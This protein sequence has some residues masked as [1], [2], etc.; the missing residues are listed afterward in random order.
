MNEDLDRHARATAEARRELV[1]VT[2]KVV[3][4]RAV[5]VG[6]LQDVVRAATQLDDGQAAQLLEA[7]EQLV[8]TALGAQ[9]DAESAVGA[10]D[11]ISRS[12]GLDQLTGLPN[13]ALL[14][15]RLMNAI[16]NAKR[17]DHRVALMFLDLNNF[18]QI[19]DRFGHA[20]GDR[21]LQLMADC[22]TSL[23]RQTDT[24]SRHGGDEFLIL[25]AEIS[26]AADAA[27][28]AEKVNTALRAYGRVDDHEVHLSVSIG[29]SMYPDDGEDAQTLIDRAD[30]AM[31]RAKAQ[32]SG[33]FAFHA[34]QD[35][36]PR[37]QLTPSVHAARRRP[38]QP[39]MTLVEHEQRHAELQE[40]NE[41]LVL[42][43]LVAQQ[44]LAAAERAGRP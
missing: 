36:N 37:D 7:N 12:A 33:G 43:A 42:S 20:S 5:L 31:Y 2:A 24:V 39:R 3:A 40:A 23:V 26:Q 32:A 30:A 9:I 21:A 41:Q 16:A 18:K 13:R 1:R 8:I 34:A 11:E 22:L 14:L 4:M 10:L 17:R 35:R 38:T 25:L 27:L 15:D 29:I 19:N 28:I 44:R 6:L